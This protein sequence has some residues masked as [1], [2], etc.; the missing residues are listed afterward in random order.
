VVSD[1]PFEYD[2]QKR[3]PDTTKA[4]EVLGFEATTSLD[5][6]LDEVIPWV[7]QAVTDN[8]L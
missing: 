8:R 5:T 3:V 6:M 2:V 1:D 7:T 4:R